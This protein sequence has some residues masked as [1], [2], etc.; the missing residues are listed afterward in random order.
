VSTNKPTD[1][2]AKPK[3]DVTTS[4]NK[5]TQHASK[6]VGRRKK[7]MWVPKDST[8]IKTKLITRTSTARLI[9]KSK[10][11]MISKVLMSKYTNKRADP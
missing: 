11:H 2:N 1:P 8:T 4:F 7:T 10:P 9:L 6:V 3:D 5:I